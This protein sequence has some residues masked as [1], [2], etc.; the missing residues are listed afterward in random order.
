MSNNEPQREMTLKEWMARLPAT[1]T[2]NVELAA[3]ERELAE[4]RRDNAKL[5]MAFD[6]EHKACENKIAELAE[7][8][9]AIESV[10]RDLTVIEYTCDHVNYDHATATALTNLY[11]KAKAALEGDH[12]GR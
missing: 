2:A 8:R 11:L 5:R 3:L 10:C 1:H 6:F 9:T 7:A 4:A 12:D